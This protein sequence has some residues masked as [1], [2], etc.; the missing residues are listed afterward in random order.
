MQVHPL[1]AAA[2]LVAAPLAATAQEFTGG[3][4]GIQTFVFT[5]DFDIGT[6][7]YSGSA[8][9]ELWR[10]VG[11]AAN[12]SYYGLSAL[13]SDARNLTL[14]GFY[15]LGGI[16]AGAFYS[17]DGSDAGTDNIYGVEGAFDLGG[18]AIAAYAGVLDGDSGTGA[19][20]GADASFALTNQI[21]GTANAG[22]VTIEDVDQA[23]FGAGAAYGLTEGLELFADVSRLSRSDDVDSDAQVAIGLGARLVLGPE[24][25]T[26]FNSRSAFDS[27]FGF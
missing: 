4:L 22:F 6:T 12:G 10:G 7:V 27:A 17:L 25:G 26:T 5:D 2:V 8:E 20:F 11:V 18:G 13:D 16:T 21:T 24:R 19:L 23:R 9:V 14:H 15:D 3:T 1:L